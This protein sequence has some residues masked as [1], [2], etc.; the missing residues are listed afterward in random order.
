MKLQEIWRVRRAH[1]NQRGITTVQAMVGLG[2]TATLAALV[3]MNGT[4]QVAA[5]EQTACEFDKSV[6]L[7]AVEAFRAS[8]ETLAYPAPVGDDGL[9]R[10]RD[11]GW[12]RTESSYWRFAGVDGTGKP[13]LVIRNA[14]TGCD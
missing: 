8:D 5:A 12:L 3:A 4:E 2:G 9:D 1:M 6:V 10:V 13:Q 11:S 7:T 14:V